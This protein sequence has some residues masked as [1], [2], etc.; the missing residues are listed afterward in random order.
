MPDLYSSYAQ[1]AA[2][3]I[4]GIDFQRLWRVSQ[5]STLVCFA[6]HGGGIE[7]GS[8]EIADVVA[9]DIHN[10]YALD[11]FKSAGTNDDL[12][13][14]STRYD[15][16]QA[17]KMAAAATHAVSFHGASGTTAATFLGGADYNLRDQ[18][19]QCLKDAGF[20]VSVASEE[21]NGNDPLNICNRT[22]R[23]MGVQLELT[24]AQRQAFFTGGDTNRAN[25]GN[26]TTAFTTYAT[27]VKLGISK[28]LVTAVAG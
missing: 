17:L 20:T 3:Q 11:G 25:R 28:A 2:A 4:E 8:Q 9:G 23:G 15:E 7:P 18:I 12:H 5:V 16:A 6:I 27:A 24:T 14:T 1:L 19:G 13:V 22:S 21:L 26:R 10:F